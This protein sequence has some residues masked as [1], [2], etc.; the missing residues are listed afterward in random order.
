[1]EIL[2]GSG[3]PRPGAGA[4]LSPGLFIARNACGVPARVCATAAWLGDTGQPGW[5]GDGGGGGDIQP[6]P[7][8]PWAA[9][10]SC[11]APLWGQR[12][13]RRSGGAV[14]C[15]AICSRPWAHARGAAG[16]CGAV[17]LLAAGR[18]REKKKEKEKHKSLLL[19]ENEA[20]EN[21]AAG[22]MLRVSTPGCFL[23][24]LR[25]GGWCPLLRRWL[26]LARSPGERRRGWGRGGTPAFPADPGHGGGTSAAAAARCQP[27]AGKC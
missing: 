14:P 18:E 6:S 5:D 9:R 4:G 27:P 23:G 2:G 25:S 16:G 22:V 21:E 26:A 24:A 7:G 15:R 10:L 17:P 19:W 13:A 8:Q 20:G 12:W 3:A 11:L 1:M